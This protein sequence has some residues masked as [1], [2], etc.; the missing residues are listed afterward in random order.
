MGIFKKSEESEELRKARQQAE[1]AKLQ[2]Q[3]AKSAAKA[4]RIRA[5]ADMQQA[6]AERYRTVTEVRRKNGGVGAAVRFA[7][8]PP[9][10]GKGPGGKPA[11]EKASPKAGRTGAGRRRK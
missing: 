8:L 4:Q 7:S 10:K 11:A 1:I 2:E 9:L 5:Q 6:R 3:A